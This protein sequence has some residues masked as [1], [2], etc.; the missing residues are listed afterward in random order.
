MAEEAAA[1]ATNS[2]RGR[3]PI[4]SFLE[5]VLETAADTRIIYDARIAVCAGSR[6]DALAAHEGDQDESHTFQE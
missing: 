6:R 1:T 3:D 2:K 4:V 5:H